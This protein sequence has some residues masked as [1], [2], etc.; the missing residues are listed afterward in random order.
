MP[1][2]P[3]LRFGLPLIRT[4]APR[5]EANAQRADPDKKALSKGNRFLLAQ[6]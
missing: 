5:T 3:P 2:E 4:V 1:L 6:Q